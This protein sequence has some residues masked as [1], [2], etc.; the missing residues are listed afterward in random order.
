MNGKFGSHDFYNHPR[1][2]FPSPLVIVGAAF[3]LSLILAAVWAQ[4]NNAALYRAEQ[5]AEGQEGATGP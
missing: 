3:A 2:R 5:M 4:S 1:H